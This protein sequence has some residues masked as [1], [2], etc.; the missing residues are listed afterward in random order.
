[1]S[2][3]LTGNTIEE[4]CDYTYWAYTSYIDLNNPFEFDYLRQEICPGFYSDM[5]IAQKTIDE[6]EQGI[7]STSFIQKLTTTIHKTYKAPGVSTKVF[8]NMN[9]LDSY[10]LYTIASAASANDLDSSELP[11]ASTLT[12]EIYSDNTVLAYVN[13][14][15]FTP[16]GCT[17][18]NACFAI[19]FIDALYAKI[20]RTD[21]SAHCGN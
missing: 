9:T 21:Y 7:V 4:T 3:I 18:G 20:D 2:T 6:D 8:T 15:A 10:H 17:E 16:V 12:F 1:M 11:P 14:T 19:D 5:N 13:E